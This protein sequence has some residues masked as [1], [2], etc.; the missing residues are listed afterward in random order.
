MKKARICMNVSVK[1][2]VLYM[3]PCVLFFLQDLEK[4]STA[5]GVRASCCYGEHSHTKI[6][7]LVTKITYIKMD[8]LI[9]IRNGF[10]NGAPPHSHFYAACKSRHESSMIPKALKFATL[11]KKMAPIP[12]HT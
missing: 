2:S 8:P 9:Y 12:P 7:P 5:V 10:A 11:Q 1:L 3:V 4:F 6:A